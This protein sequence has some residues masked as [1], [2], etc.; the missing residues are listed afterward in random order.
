M[1]QESLLER[2]ALAKEIG[3]DNGY[4]IGQENAPD[5][6]P[7]QKEQFM[8]DCLET[9][10]VHFRQFSPFEFTAQEFNRSVHFFDNDGNVVKEE[11]QEWVNDKIWEK[12]NAGVYEGL[13]K[14]WKEWT[15]IF[16]LAFR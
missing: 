6:K 16:V 13:L 1:K 10:M 11:V 3:F 9:E 2:Y 4:G 8:A 14:A 7:G 15:Q 5:Y 12:Y